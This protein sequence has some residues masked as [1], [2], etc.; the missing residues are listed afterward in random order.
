M[1]FFFIKS[2]WRFVRFGAVK[3]RFLKSQSHLQGLE[4]ETTL[5]RAEMFARVFCG[6][7]LSLGNWVLN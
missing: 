4:Q 7:A 1:A 2:P 3:V 5:S 6:H